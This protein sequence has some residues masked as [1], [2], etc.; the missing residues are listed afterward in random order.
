M[1]LPSPSA[2]ARGLVLVVEDDDVLRFLVAKALRSAGYEVEA[3]ADGQ[4]ALQLLGTRTFEVVLSDISMPGMDG[5]EMLRQ[6]RALDFDL[7][8]ILLTGQPRLETAIQAVESGALRY[9][10]KPVPTAEILEAVET[11]VRLCRLARWKRDALTYL[12]DRRLV[13]DRTALEWPWTT[14]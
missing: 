5:V 1:S 6:V 8:V 3:A 9:L 13:A 2:P 4:E 14:P 10:Q 12:G 7:P 11:A